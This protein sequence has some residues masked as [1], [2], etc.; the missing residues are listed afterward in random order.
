MRMPEKVNPRKS[1]VAYFSIFYSYI[2]FVS[3]EFDAQLV[4]LIPELI[5]SS[6]WEFSLSVKLSNRI[7]SS[8][9]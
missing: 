7:E 4:G 8:F 5:I 6:R 9:I 1:Q 2:L 3:Y